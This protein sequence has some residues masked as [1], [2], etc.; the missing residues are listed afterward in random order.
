MEIDYGNPENFRRPFI[1]N[2]E[3][4]VDQ[5]L[6]LWSTKEFLENFYKTIQS[7]EAI[8]FQDATY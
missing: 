4:D 2:Y 7:G 3:L 8:I 5:F 6:V 1:L